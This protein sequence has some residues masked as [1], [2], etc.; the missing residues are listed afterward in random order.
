[1]TDSVIYSKDYISRSGSFLLEVSMGNVEGW[2]II[3]K[4]GHSDAV[5]TTIVPVA[6]GNIY[7]TPTTAETLE[8]VSNN[9]ADNQ[10]GIGARSVVVEGLDENFE[11]QSIEAL[12][13]ATD[14]TVAEEI[15][16][17][18][19][20]RVFRAYVKDSGTYAS[21]SAGSHQGSLTIRTSGGAGQDW[22]SIDPHTGFP[23]GQSEIGVYTIPKGKKG[24]IGDI[25]TETD[26]AKTVDI[27]FFRRSGA[28]IVTAPYTSMRALAVF[29]GVT[30]S[31]DLAPKTWVGPFDEYTDIG[32]M[33]VRS[34]AGTSSVSVDFEILLQDQ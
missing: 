25:H 31:Q 30:D 7:P 1:M 4:F 14:G 5:S 16:G 10:A 6:S 34:S 26:S 15:T 24:W 19:W 18:Q 12:T 32:F 3:H 21:Q 13:H 9:I 28:N 27:L 20:I 11:L 22:A 33:A 23:L 29:T 8:I 2:D 17:Y